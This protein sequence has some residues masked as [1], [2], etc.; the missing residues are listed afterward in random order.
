MWTNATMFT[1]MI[2]YRLLFFGLFLLSFGLA[3]QEDYVRFRRITINDGL[4]LSSVYN[5]FY[6][7]EQ[8]RGIHLSFIQQYKIKADR[9]H[10]LNHTILER[11]H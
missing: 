9:Y 1:G 10:L 7:F 11:N 6:Q 2:R 4:S 3:A 8:I 5:I